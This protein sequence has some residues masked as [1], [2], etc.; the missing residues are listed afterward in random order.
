MLHA[1]K[2]GRNKPSRTGKS[3]S[4]FDYASNRF[5]QAE[6]DYSSGSC[7]NILLAAIKN[8]PVREIKMKKA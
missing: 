6:N 4:V 3:L 5:S 2:L 8:N 7:A 1:L